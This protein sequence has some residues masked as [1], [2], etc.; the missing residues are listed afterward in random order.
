MAKLPKLSLFILRDT[1][2]RHLAPNQTLQQSRV[3][4]LK[5]RGKE[6]Y[7][8]RFVPKKL[9]QIIPKNASTPPQEGCLVLCFACPSLVITQFTDSTTIALTISGCEDPNEVA[10]T[11]RAPCWNHKEPKVCPTRELEPG[12]YV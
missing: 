8:S 6:Y 1:S 11:S 7:R 9:K 2:R 5:D 12:G 4:S 10:F 3:Y